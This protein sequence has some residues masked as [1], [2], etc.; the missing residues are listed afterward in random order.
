MHVVLHAQ[1]T[2]SSVGGG[3]RTLANKTKSVAENN[4]RQKKKP[5]QLNKKPTAAE[6]ARASKKKPRQLK[7]PS[8]VK[9]LQ[10]HV[11]LSTVLTKL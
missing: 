6:N 11:R 7:K 1:K 2:P 5:Q 8:P 9:D 10:E 3:G 4:P